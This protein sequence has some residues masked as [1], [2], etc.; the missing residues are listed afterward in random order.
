MPGF[1]VECS[2]C[3]TSVLSRDL[4]LHIMRTHKDS[5]FSSKTPEGNTNRKSSLWSATYLTQPIPLDIGK[6][7]EVFFCLA[8]NTCFRSLTKAEMHMKTRKDNHQAAILALRETFPKL[9]DAQPETPAS[10]LNGK[11][12]Q[13]LQDWVATLCSEAP[14]TT[15]SNQDRKIFEKIGI[16]TQLADLKEMYPNIFAEPEEEPE[17]EPEPVE[18]LMEEATPLPDS[19]PVKE[20]PPPPPPPTVEQVIVKKPS[21]HPA[22]MQ[23]YCNRTFGGYRQ[24]TFPNLIVNTKQ[25]KQ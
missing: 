13:K 19:E 24:N 9:L 11:E 21:Y 22:D 18:E 20:T 15:F 12:K 4:G 8:D 6:D 14:D 1:R 16:K 25:M 17:P 7:Q 23:T 5:L 10:L 2:Y 3:K